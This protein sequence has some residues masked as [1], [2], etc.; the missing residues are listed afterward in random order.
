M[1]YANLVDATGSVERVEAKR[2]LPAEFRGFEIAPAQI[3]VGIWLRMALGEEMET[4]PAPVGARDFLCLAKESDKE[5]QHEVS[6]DLRLELEIA[7]EIFAFD[8]PETALEIE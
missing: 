8:F 2:V 4:K 3:R 6:I 5:Q 1:E 7:G